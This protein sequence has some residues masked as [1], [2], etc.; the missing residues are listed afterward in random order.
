MPYM[1][2]D[3]G[4]ARTR[5]HPDSFSAVAEPKR[6]RTLDA[7]G[8]GERS[9]GE[10]VTTL[11]LPQ[12]QVSKH[13]GA[14]RRVGLVRVRREGKRRLYSVDAGRLRPI[15]EWVSAYERMWQGQLLSVKELAEA[16]ARAG[17]TPREIKRRRARD[18]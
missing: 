15:H 1:A 12:P 11:G 6:R 16:S 7:L 17:A 14:L 10:L 9:V 5:A 4:V 3:F 18:A 2:Y 13:L 8:A